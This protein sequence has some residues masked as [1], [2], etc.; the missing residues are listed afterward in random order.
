MSAASSLPIARRRP[1]GLLTGA[2][3]TPINAHSV[4]HRHHQPTSNIQH[5]IIRTFAHRSHAPKP[6]PCRRDGSQSIAASTVSQQRSL[7]AG[8]LCDHFYRHHSFRH[9]TTTATIVACHNKLGAL[10]HTDSGHSCTRSQFN[11]RQFVG[12]PA[13]D[14]VRRQN[15]PFVRSVVRRLPADL[16]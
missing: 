12:A 6:K 16:I 8:R 1:V 4:N 7:C 10:A 9:T 13:I 14:R 15:R 2:T 11:A 3:R 5:P